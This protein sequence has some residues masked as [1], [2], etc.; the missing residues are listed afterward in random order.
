M[1]NRGTARRTFDA[2]ANAVSAEQ[3]VSAGPEGAEA[4]GPQWQFTQDDQR[5]WRWCRLDGDGEATESAQVFPDRARCVID[6]MRDA[7]QRRKAL[8]E[9]EQ[10]VVP[11]EA[12]SAAVVSAQSDATLHIQQLDV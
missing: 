5:Q 3:N 4:M 11:A 10:G 7:V 2:P 8:V 12:G 9:R 6:A 1:G